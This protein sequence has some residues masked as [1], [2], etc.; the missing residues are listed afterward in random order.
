MVGG[1]EERGKGKEDKGWKGA[2]EKLRRERGRARGMEYR[3]V[4]VEN[5]SITCIRLHHVAIFKRMIDP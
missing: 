3:V 5:R 4:V 1:G 2:A